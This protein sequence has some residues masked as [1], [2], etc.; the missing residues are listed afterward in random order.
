[1]IT[2]D[3]SALCMPVTAP[4]AT[5]PPAGTRLSLR[6]TGRNLFA[7][8]SCGLNTTPTFGFASL[9][10]ADAAT[11]LM[12][13]L[14]M[15]SLATAA[16]TPVA[17]TTPSENAGDAI[18]MQ[19]RKLRSRQRNSV[20]VTS[21]ATSPPGGLDS[22]TAGVTAAVTATPILPVASAQSAGPGSVGSSSG[23]RTPRSQGVL[24]SGN[25][26]DPPILRS[27]RNLQSEAGRGQGWQ[28]EAPEFHKDPL[29]LQASISPPSGTSRLLGAKENTSGP[30]TRA[31]TA[32]AAAQRRSRARDKKEE[33]EVSS[34]EST[35]GKVK[36]AQLVN[37]W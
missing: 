14:A 20:G 5:C 22:P 11:P 29:S 9:D 19:T 33:E 37:G 12:G 18:V 4:K 7:N 31:Q 2:P 1:M 8:S 3:T 32:K 16:S 13:N 21:S 27:Q 17:A 23:A 24:Q 28:L 35:V 30:R 15:F 25:R 26:Y 34:A 6:K 36:E 10:D